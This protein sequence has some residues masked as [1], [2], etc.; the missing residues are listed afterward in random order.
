[1]CMVVCLSVVGIGV[2]DD[3]ALTQRYHPNQFRRV[4]ELQT[5]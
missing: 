5:L 4:G 3:S 1:M 2:R